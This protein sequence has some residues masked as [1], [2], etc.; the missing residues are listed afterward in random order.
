MDCFCVIWLSKKAFCFLDKC[1][2]FLFR[3][4]SANFNARLLYSVTASLS[5]LAYASSYFFLLSSLLTYC[6]NSS[7]FL[8]ASWKFVFDCSNLCLA[9]LFIFFAAASVFSFLNFIVPLS[10]TSSKT[11]ILSIVCL[12]SLYIPL[13]VES[14]ISSLGCVSLNHFTNS[15]FF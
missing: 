11:S 3:C 2:A 15:D 7:Y 8:V 9:I 12:S 10:V 5:D 13:R 4:N 1:C 6:C 14:F